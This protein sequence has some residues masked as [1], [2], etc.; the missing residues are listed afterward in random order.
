MP[1]KEKTI[2]SNGVYVESIMAK[3]AV[4]TCSFYSSLLDRTNAFSNGLQSETRTMNE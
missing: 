4:N 3:A 2:H 1:T